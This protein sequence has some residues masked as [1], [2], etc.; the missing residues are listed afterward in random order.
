[1][2][3]HVADEHPTRAAIDSKPPHP[4]PRPQE[5]PIGVLAGEGELPV[6]EP[7]EVVLLVVDERLVVTLSLLPAFHLDLVASSRP[8]PALLGLGPAFPETS[9][10]TFHEP[11]GG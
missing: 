1:M 11:I 3:V 8:D 6:T 5:R 2:L 4:A 9:L 7:E 10:A